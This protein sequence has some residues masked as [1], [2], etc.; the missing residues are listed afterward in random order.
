MKP[1][2]I[3]FGN[4]QADW[5][6]RAFQTVPEIRQRYDVAFLPSFQTPGLT[7]P[8]AEPD[9]LDRCELLLEQRGAWDRFPWGHALPPSTRSVTFPALAFEAQWPL[10]TF[11]DPR[12]VP[13]LPH[14]PYGRFPYGDRLIAQWLREGVARDQILDRYLSSSIH[15]VEDLARIEELSMVR[16]EL[17]D[18]QCDIAMADF[19]I[20]RFRTEPL[21]YT[22]NHARPPLL[23]ALALRVLE[24]SDLGVDVREASRATQAFLE[25]ERPLANI[26]VPIHPEVADALRL[27]WYSPDLRYGCFELADVSYEDYWRAFVA[28][29]PPRGAAA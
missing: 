4:C 6:A 8:R 18:A 28:Y 17:A 22:C 7:P 29:D 23:S 9:L 12:N 13:D 14:Y 27:E 5:V 24:A 11:S 16:M 3:V 15:D 1:S 21:F 2:L 20:A 10:T 19:V 26:Q 25:R